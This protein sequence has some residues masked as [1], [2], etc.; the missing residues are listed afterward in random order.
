MKTVA[1]ID[2]LISIPCGFTQ[3]GL[4]IGVQFITR[5][6]EEALLFQMAHSYEEVSPSRDLRPPV[7][8]GG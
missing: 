7:T 3:A 6:F 5:P 4:L 8:A 2:L 1:N